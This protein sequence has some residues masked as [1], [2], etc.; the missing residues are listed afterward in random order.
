MTLSHSRRELTE[1]CGGW[2]VCSN[3][4]EGG[5]SRYLRLEISRNLLQR[6]SKAALEAAVVILQ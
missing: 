5:G 3:G 6:S 4:V 2:G 1:L